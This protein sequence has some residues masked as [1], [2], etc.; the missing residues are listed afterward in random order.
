[1]DPEYRKRLEQWQKFN[2]WKEQQ[3]ENL[4]E[5][6][7]LRQFFILADMVR[8]YP[9]DVVEK[10]HQEHLENLIEI[11]KSFREVYNNLS[12]VSG[13]LSAKS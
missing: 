6:E 7:R 2:A 9:A 13:Q 10:A 3:A 8:F 1:M 11:Q 5:E 4:S 12:A